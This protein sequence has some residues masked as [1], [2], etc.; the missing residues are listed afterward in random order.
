[1]IFQLMMLKRGGKIPWASAAAYMAQGNAQKKSDAYTFK[2]LD[3]LL[4]SDK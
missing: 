4:S 1:M 2:V 3:Y